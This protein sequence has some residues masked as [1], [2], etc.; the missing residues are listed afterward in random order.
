MSI[1]WDLTASRQITGEW[2]DTD[3]GEVGA[4]C[5]PADRRWKWLR[6]AA[7]SWRSRWRRRRL[8]VRGRGAAAVVRVHWPSRRRRGA[9]RPKKR[10]KGDRA[11]PAS[12]ELLMIER[13]PE[14]WIA[15]DHILDLRARSGCGTRW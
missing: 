10:A 14:S 9:Q 6:V 13:L 2:I 3:T 5:G 1:V 12:R 7:G 15:P 4:A 8:A 11:T